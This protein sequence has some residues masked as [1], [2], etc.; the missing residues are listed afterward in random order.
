MTEYRSGL[1]EQVNNAIAADKLHRSMPQD[2]VQPKQFQM[3]QSESPPLSS[4]ISQTA[5][6]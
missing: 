5:P 3:K 1:R 6:W 2:C 4:R